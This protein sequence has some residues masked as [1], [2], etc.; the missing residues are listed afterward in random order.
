MRVSQFTTLA[1]L[2]SGIMSPLLAVEYQKMSSKEKAAL[3]DQV[4][5]QLP[6]KLKGRL[7]AK[8]VK[9]RELLFPHRLV[10]AR[11]AS[12][13]ICL[14]DDSKKLVVVTPLSPQQKKELMDHVKKARNLK[15]IPR[16]YLRHIEADSMY[17]QQEARE[18]LP[19]AYRTFTE[20]YIV[21]AAADHY[22]SLH[23][24]SSPDGEH[25][26]EL[27][28]RCTKPSTTNV[29]QL[30]AAGASTNY[31]PI[32]KDAESDLHRELQ[33]DLMGQ[34]SRLLSERLDSNL[35]LRGLNKESWEQ[36]WYAGRFLPL[37][38]TLAAQQ[39]QAAA[40][41]E[42]ILSGVEKLLETSF[43]RHYLGLTTLVTQ[44]PNC[45]FQPEDAEALPDA[46]RASWQPLRLV[47]PELEEGF[48]APNVAIYYLPT[49]G[50]DYKAI[51]RRALELQAESIEREL[52]QLQRGYARF[53]KEHP[54]Q[55]AAAAE[56]AQEWKRALDSY[57]ESV[58]GEG[59]SLQREL[60]RAL[61]ELDASADPKAK[62]TGKSPV[63]EL[64]ADLMKK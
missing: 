17:S 52:K 46:D 8:S 50:T 32:P 4:K 28:V 63:Y 33:W 18:T 15:L 53:L 30:G 43:G 34:L 6:A 35:Y 60:N 12:T 47:I 22:I 11:N 58:I 49:R 21:Y 37:P 55:Q 5:A 38:I 16:D 3:Y 54:I 27:A 45:Y 44:Y 9:G 7:S 19:I 39:R 1:L 24:V 48:I 29:M 59:G 25:A 20:D 14:D 36:G 40:P 57:V 10:I 26:P 51:S 42:N 31:F 62:K 23:Q 61:E 56:L 2:L 41:T 64:G 13:L